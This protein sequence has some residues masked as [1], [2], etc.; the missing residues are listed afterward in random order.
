MGQSRATR[1]LLNLGRFIATFNSC[2]EQS[3]NSSNIHREY[4]QALSRIRRNRLS[5]Q[6]QTQNQRID[7]SVR[8]SVIAGAAADDRETCG[9]VELARRIVVDGDL[10]YNGRQAPPRRFVDRRPQQHLG[11]AAPPPSRRDAE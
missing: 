8:P 7:P 3:R 2:A 6:S 5:R 9:E 11:D 4:P 1:Y 10:E